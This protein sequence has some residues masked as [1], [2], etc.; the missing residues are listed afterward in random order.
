[1]RYRIR[2]ATMIRKM[3]PPISTTPRLYGSAMVAARGLKSITRPNRIAI[4][5]STSGHQPSPGWPAGR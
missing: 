4:A 3:P 2:N 5:P 1:M